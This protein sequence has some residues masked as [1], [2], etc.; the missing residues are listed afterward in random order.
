M[1]AMAS[2][3]M[4]GARRFKRGSGF[5]YRLPLLVRGVLS[6]LELLL[7][8]EPSHT[9]VRLPKLQSVEVTPRPAIRLLG[10]HDLF[11]RVPTCQQLI[12]AHVERERESLHLV[13]PERPRAVL[14]LV[15]HRLVHRC[16]E[17]CEQF[18]EMGLAPPAILS[19]D[20]DPLADGR[21]Y[22]DRTGCLLLSAH[23]NESTP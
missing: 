5:G 12:H 6:I 10:R 9:R 13:D 17:V 11:A 2:P 23:E 16:A 1:L 8:C 20:S 3:L 19:M 15:D 14:Q 7:G 4:S 21:F 22:V 18:A